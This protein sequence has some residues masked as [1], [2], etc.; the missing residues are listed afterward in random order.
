M[1]ILRF[2]RETIFLSGILVSAVILRI[3]GVQFGLPFLYHADEPIVVNH[4]LAFGTGDLNPHFFNIPPLVSYLL[5][6][7]YGIYYAA[8]WAAGIF[9]S[10]RDFEQLFYFD[11]TSFYLIARLIF[12]VFF[13]TLSV[14]VLFRLVKRFGNVRTALWA[15]FFLAANFLHV[16]DSHYIYADI[17]LLFVLLLGFFVIFRLSENPSS[18]KWHLLAGGMIGLATA[19]K[20]NGVFLAIPYLW[21][22][23]RCVPWKQWVALWLLAAVAAGAVFIIL[24]PYAV[25][26]HTFFLKEIAEQSAANSGGS[27]WLHH[28]TYSLAGALGGLMLVLALLGV[29]RALLSKDVRFQALAVFVAGYYAVLCHFGQPYDRYVLPLIP[30]MLVLAAEVLAR[31]KAKSPLLFWILIP[32]VV[33]PS[34]IKTIHWDR[35]M[36]EPDVRTAAKEWVEANIPAGSPLALDGTF[37]MPRLSF[38]P[39]QL[40]KKRAHAAEGFQ[41]VAKMR[42]LDALLSRPYQPSYG[43]NFLSHNSEKPGFLFAEPLVPYDLEE[44]IQKGIQYVLLIDAR[45]SDGEPFFQA[46]QASADRVK[47]FSPFRDSRDLTIHDPQTMTGGPFLWGDIRPRE[48]GGYP[49]SIYRVRS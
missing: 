6:V 9:H 45:H 13:G 42:R 17:P 33:L 37:F 12:G 36:S 40:E 5:F 26:D 22:C 21:V 16:R 2:S 35:L 39:Q 7:C 47:T 23:I 46:L 11:S 25:L 32:F 28:L 48:R 14:Y 15:S 43:L 49:V 1:K 4:A 3:W 10:V 38:S 34:I 29:F 18:W 44:L 41:S 19:T 8:G 27:P 20:Y 31:I 30:F 24:N